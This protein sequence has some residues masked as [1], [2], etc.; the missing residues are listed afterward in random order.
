MLILNTNRYI[1]S[2]CLLDYN[3]VAAVDKF[4][5]FFVLRLPNS[6]NDNNYDTISSTSN[7]NVLWNQGILNGAPNKLELLAC[8]YI[9]EL[10]T[11]IC[12]TSLVQGSSE[13]IFVGS[14]LGGIYAFLPFVSTADKEFF[15][16]L[17]MFMRQEKVTLCQRDHLSYRSYYEPV[18]HVI[19][20]DLC[21]LFTLMPIKKQTEM[22]SDVDR[23]P[24]EINKK[25]EDIRNY[26]M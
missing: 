24:T 4:G 13:A 26:L 2:A 18:K 17:E 12:M 1:T 19:D 16:H 25:L 9:G 8:Y 11:S 14:I 23:T 5:N 15:S 22:A 7:A 6:I 3:T 10:C 20:G 21:E